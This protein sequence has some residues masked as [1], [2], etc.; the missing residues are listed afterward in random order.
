M[1]ILKVETSIG[2]EIEADRLMKLILDQRLAACIQRET[3]KSSYRWQGAAVCEAEV[4]MSCKTTMSAR[5]ELVRFLETNH[6]YEV[7]EI[8]VQ[9]VDVSDA[10]GA[11][12]QGEVLDA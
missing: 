12:V 11:W 4:R 9:V 3:I 2:G 6:P 10:Y 7:P 8:L 1:Q 5:G